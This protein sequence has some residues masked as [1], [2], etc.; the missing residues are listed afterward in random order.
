MRRRRKSTLVAAL[1]GLLV[2]AGSI[3]AST[4]DGPGAP[5]W[6]SGQAGGPGSWDW[7][8]PL[9]LVAFL[10]VLFGAAIARRRRTPARA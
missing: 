5:P 2:A 7:W 4:A 9:L 6:E 10:L 1:F 3:A 8:P